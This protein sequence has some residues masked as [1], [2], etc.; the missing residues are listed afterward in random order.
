[1]GLRKLSFHEPSGPYVPT[2]ERITAG[3][4]QKIRRGGSFNYF[5]DTY[6]DPEG[7]RGEYPNPAFI[8]MTEADGAWMARILVASTIR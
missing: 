2:A 4:E 8:R 1:V 3:R 7:W 5:A 6:F